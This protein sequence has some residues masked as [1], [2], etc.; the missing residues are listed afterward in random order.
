M[1]GCGNFRFLGLMQKAS[2]Q[3]PP[4]CSLKAADYKIISVSEWFPGRWSTIRGADRCVRNVSDPQILATGLTL[5]QRAALA[6]LIYK[7]FG[8]WSS[9]CDALVCWA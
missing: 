9:V 8:R 7:G 2:R 4:P 3:G 5:K 6:A 1:H